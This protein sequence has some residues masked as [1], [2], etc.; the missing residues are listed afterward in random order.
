[1]TAG[2]GARHFARDLNDLPEQ[3]GLWSRFLIRQ[4]QGAAACGA[5]LGKSME[6]VGWRRE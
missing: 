6:F 3:A 2:W 5:R 4:R 1:M